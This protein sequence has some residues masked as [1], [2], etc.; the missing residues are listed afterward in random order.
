[1]NTTVNQLLFAATL[2]NWIAAT[3]FC[4]RAVFSNNALY[5][6]LGSRREI[7]ATMRL[8]RTAQNFL[9]RE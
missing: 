3:N 9:A 5:V 4:D 1:M 2:L 8:L 7:F 6:I